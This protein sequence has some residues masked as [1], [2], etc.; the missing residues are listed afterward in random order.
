MRWVKLI[1]PP[2]AC[3]RWLLMSRRLASSSRAGTTRK[4]VAVGTPRLASMF[5]TVRAAAPRRG[6]AGGFA[7]DGAGGGCASAGAAFGE[8]AASGGVA[9][10]CCPLLG[11]ACGSA[12][13]AGGG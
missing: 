9:V 10:C 8:L 12:T 1:L 4:E 11:C 2:L 7:E 6:F 13:P 5:C 3:E